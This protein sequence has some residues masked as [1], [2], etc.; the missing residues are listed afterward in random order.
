MTCQNQHLWVS[1][2]DFTF[3]L[4]L[5]FIPCNQSS[6]VCH[7]NVCRGSKVWGS[8]RISALLGTLHGSRSFSS[9]L[10]ALCS[11]WWATG[12]WNWTK[13]NSE[14]QKVLV[15]YSAT[16]IQERLGAL[17]FWSP[18]ISGS[19]QVERKFHM[20]WLLPTQCNGHQISAA[21]EKNWTIS[22]PRKA[23]AS[24]STSCRAVSTLSQEFQGH[25][26]HA[27]VAWAWKTLRFISSVE[28][29]K[30]QSPW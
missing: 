1:K 15:N 5:K 12:T 24:T 4:L 7:C 13:N 6:K 30:S 2:C 9:Y 17:R 19:F 14:L 20:S 28:K 27:W 23:A 16:S 22:V 3:T 26:Q 11:G 29:S 18:S 8:R 25:C 21:R 10:P